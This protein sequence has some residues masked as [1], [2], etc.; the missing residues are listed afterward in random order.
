MSFKEEYP[1]TRLQAAKWLRQGQRLVKIFDQG[2]RTVE[3]MIRA[4][5]KRF[6]CRFWSGGTL[7]IDISRKQLLGFIRRNYVRSYLDAEPIA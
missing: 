7:W 5:G 2:E 3:V 4:D 1:V 6:I